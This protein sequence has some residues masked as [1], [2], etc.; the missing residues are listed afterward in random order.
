[1][2]LRTFIKKV[3]KE[4]LTR[5]ED[6]SEGFSFDAL[7][8]CETLEDAEQYAKTHL[9]RVGQGLFRTAYGLDD[10]TVLK[11]LRTDGDDIDHMQNAQEARNASCL[12]K[13]YVAQVLRKHPE[14]WWIVVERVNPLTIEKFIAELEKR[15][16][17]I[18]VAK[19]ATEMDTKP[20]STL[21]GLDS[22]ENAFMMAVEYA[23]NSP[24]SSSPY[25]IKQWMTNKW[26]R[27]LIQAIRTCQVEAHDFH[28]KNWGIR[29]STN[30][31]VILDLGF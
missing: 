11:V 16:G 8:A 15:L 25:N 20:V 13:R 28:H 26:Y 7:N 21:D 1:M 31:L 18:P 12:P 17:P 27:G 22:K 6:R 9:E 14:F 3:L 30:E 4:E 10:N 2:N 19:N 29:A 24:S 23:V 5:L